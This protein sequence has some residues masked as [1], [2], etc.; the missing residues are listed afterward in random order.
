MKLRVPTCDDAKSP[1]LKALVHGATALL[2]VMIVVYHLYNVR[3]HWSHR[4]SRSA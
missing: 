3:F 4:S 2:H 1:T